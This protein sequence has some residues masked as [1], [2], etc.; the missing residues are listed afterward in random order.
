MFQTQSTLS[1]VTEVIVPF[2][3]VAFTLK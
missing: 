3:Y 2:V 1:F